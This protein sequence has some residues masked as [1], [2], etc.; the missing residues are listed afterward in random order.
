MSGLPWD[1]LDGLSVAAG[2]VN[3]G[4]VSEI[5]VLPFISQVTVILSGSIR[6][7]MKDPGTLD[8]PYSLDLQRPVPSG[9]PGFT[10]AADFV[11]EVNKRRVFA[12]TICEQVS[13]CY[14]GFSSKPR[15]ILSFLPNAIAQRLI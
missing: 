8:E 13:Y 14:F 11:G 10:T 4:V 15:S 6:I 9:K 7:L 5:T 1:I 2:Q 3:P 12:K